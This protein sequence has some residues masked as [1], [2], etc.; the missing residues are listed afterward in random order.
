MSI[1]LCQRALTLAAPLSGATATA[2]ATAIGGTLAAAGAAPLAVV[3]LPFAAAVGIG[4]GVSKIW[5]SIFD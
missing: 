1:L 3:A 5:N 4:W 2:A